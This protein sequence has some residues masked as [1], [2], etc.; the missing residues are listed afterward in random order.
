[1]RIL[2]KSPFTELGSKPTIQKTNAKEQWQFA[3]DKFQ[4]AVGEVDSLGKQSEKLTQDAVLGRVDNLHDV[5][6]AAEKAR[7][8]MNLTLEV[9]N[10]ALDAYK[11][12]MRMNF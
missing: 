10:K 5:M 2:S 9:R 6:I 4:T 11:E 3:L 12:I 1:M 8:A 7:T